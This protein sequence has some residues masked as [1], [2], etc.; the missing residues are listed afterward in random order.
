MKS[1][2]YFGDVNML[3]TKSPVEREGSQLVWVDKE[4]IRKQKGYDFVKRLIDFFA[5][6]IGIILISPIMIWIGYKIYKDEPGSA[7]LPLTRTKK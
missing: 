7:M 2:K 4:K 1:E 5:G 6:L 3:K